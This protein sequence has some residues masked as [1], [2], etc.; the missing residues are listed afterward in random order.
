MTACDDLN[1]GADPTARRAPD[2]EWGL[3]DKILSKGQRFDNL[4]DARAAADQQSEGMA[5]FAVQFALVLQE[6]SLEKVAPEVPFY[7]LSS[8]EA[9]AVC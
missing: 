1:R 6:E 5:T 2:E 4:G 9:Q 8:H 3:L 7:L